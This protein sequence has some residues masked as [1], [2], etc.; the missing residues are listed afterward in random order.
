MI[1]E[2][3]GLNR[4]RVIVVGWE[5]PMP[6]ALQL[7]EEIRLDQWVREYRPEWIKRIDE[8]RLG[9]PS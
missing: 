2:E 3:V 9:T 4:L 6:A 8:V 1:D 5:V 7:L